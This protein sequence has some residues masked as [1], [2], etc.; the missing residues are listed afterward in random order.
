MAYMNAHMK[1]GTQINLTADLAG[2]WK[3]YPYGWGFIRTEQLERRP[4]KVTITLKFFSSP[5]RD[6]WYVEGTAE[7]R[8]AGV[9]EKD[10]SYRLQRGTLDIVADCVGNT[11]ISKRGNRYAVW[12]VSGP[13]PLGFNLTLKVVFTPLSMQPP[14]DVREWDLLCASAG[15]PGLG[16]RR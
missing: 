9:S 6:R 8:E 7:N 10:L 2:G 16:K 5:S 11:E 1:K 12:K 14:K 3:R 13:G 4:V 15:L